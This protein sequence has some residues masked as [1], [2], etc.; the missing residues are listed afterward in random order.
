M[1][2]KIEDMKRAYKEGLFF[3]RAE[4]EF[5]KNGKTN[6]AGHLRSNPYHSFNSLILLIEN[7]RQSITEK[8]DS[9]AL[10]TD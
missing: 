1:R 8:Y 3:E 2:F 4:N 6:A 5:E 10:R 7:E 9:K